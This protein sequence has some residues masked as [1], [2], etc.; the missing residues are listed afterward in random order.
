MAVATRTASTAV[1]IAIV[2]LPLRSMAHLLLTRFSIL[3]PGLGTAYH[4]PILDLPKRSFLSGSAS[5]TFLAIPYFAA[6]GNDD[7]QKCSNLLID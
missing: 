4:T 3:A 5:A 2:S 6:L 1:A 7:D